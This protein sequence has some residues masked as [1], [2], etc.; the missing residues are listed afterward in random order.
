MYWH[1]RQPPTGW[2]NFLFLLLDGSVTVRSGLW[3][4]LFLSPTK[5]SVDFWCWRSDIETETF[6]HMRY[7]GTDCSLMCSSADFPPSNS[8]PS[9]GDFEKA[10][11]TRLVSLL[12][13]CF[14]IV[15]RFVCLVVQ[16]LVNSNV[17]SLCL[18]GVN[19]GNQKRTASRHAEKW[20]NWRLMLSGVR[21]RKNMCTVCML[22]S[23]DVEGR[24]TEKKT[25]WRIEA[26]IKE[27]VLVLNPVVPER[28]RKWADNDASFPAKILIC[29]VVACCLR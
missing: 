8:T 20:D 25:D 14:F 13:L 1:F 28:C 16:L 23:F 24:D 6:L 22:L 18:R 12:F 17:D 10:F 27:L 9:H 19:H 7:R 5:L 26:G 3:N 11:L 4:Y 15:D 2:L 29:V 21:A